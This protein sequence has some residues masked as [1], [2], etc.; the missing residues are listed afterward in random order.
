MRYLILLSVVAASCT[1][2]LSI[3][4]AADARAMTE[5]VAVAQS[6]VH[7]LEVE[8]TVNHFLLQVQYEASAGKR[9]RVRC[10]L[11]DLRDS[12][13]E[14]MRARGF[15]VDVQHTCVRVTW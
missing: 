13:A 10:E 3:S 11:D 12:V 2:D 1:P 7:K 5:K 14:A 9:H 6:N 4:T 15:T 8:E